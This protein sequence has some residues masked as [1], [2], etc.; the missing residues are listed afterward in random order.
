MKVLV[1][2]KGVIN[3]HHVQRGGIILLNSDEHLHRAY[4]LPPTNCTGL[5]L[6]HPLSLAQHPFDTLFINR[7]FIQVKTSCQ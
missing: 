5:Y 3:I 4:L 6:D 1:I 2:V 7:N